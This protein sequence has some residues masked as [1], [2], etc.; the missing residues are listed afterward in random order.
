MFYNLKIIEKSPS[1]YS[2]DAG[3]YEPDDKFLELVVLDMRGE[4]ICSIFITIWNPTELTDWL[5]ANEKAIRSEEFPWPFGEASSIAEAISRFYDRVDEPSG[6]E[7]E[8]LYGYRTR[9][10]FRFAMRGCR[11]PDVYVGKVKQYF[12]VSFKEETRF[13]VYRVKIDPLF[14]TNT[15]INAG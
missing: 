7:F 11:L 3:Y 10:G 15:S 8:D 9:H 13:V 6:K 14:G 12:E 4:C 2:G 1:E 5:V